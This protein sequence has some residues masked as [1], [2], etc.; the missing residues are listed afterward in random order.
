MENNT[1]APESFASITDQ[2]QQ[3]IVQHPHLKQRSVR[4]DSVDGTVTLRGSV[5]SY[6][7]KQMAQE[8]V[9]RVEGIR[10]VSNH[11]EVRP[12]LPESLNW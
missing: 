12:A 7:E 5:R 2:L 1:C 8:A 3:V 4:C 10:L 9:R 6:F 11:L